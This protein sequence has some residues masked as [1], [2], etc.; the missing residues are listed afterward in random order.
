MSSEELRVLVA[1]IQ[2]DMKLINEKVGTMS[3]VFEE[4][5]NTIKTNDIHHVQLK[6]D[7]IYKAV[8]FGVALILSNAALYVF[9][10]FS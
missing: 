9:S 2:G 3:T 7:S 1:E 4:R 5:L 10:M 6:V 8:W